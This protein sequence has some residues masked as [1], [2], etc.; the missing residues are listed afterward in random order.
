MSDRPP[1]TVAIVPHTHWD[2]EWYDTFQTFRL[3]LVKLLD[4]LLPMLESDPSYARFMLDGQTVVVDDYL[5]VRPHARA[6]LQ[7]LA[8]AGRLS[9]GPWMVLM[10]E[11][12]V[13]GETMVRDLQFGLARGSEL[14]GAMQIG[15][16]PDMFGHIAQMPQLIRLAGMKHAVAWRGVPAA[17]EQTAFWWQAPD[18]SR[19]RTEYLYGSYSNGRD[20]PQ[21]AKSLVLRAADY[22]QEL[23]PAR[24][25]AMLLMNGTDHQ[26]PQPWL[27][28]VVAEA[29][30]IQDDYEFVVTSLAEYLPTQPSDALVT[31]EG[32]LRSGARANLL[33]GVASNRV[34]VHRAC[35]AAERSLE[36]RAEP[37]SALFLPPDRYPHS[38]A[39]IAWRNLVCNSAHDSSCACSIDEVVDQV[40]VRYYEARQIGDGLTR[41]AVHALAATV[42]AALGAT[43]VVNPTARRRSGLVEVTLPGTGAVHIVDTS[44][45]PRPTQIIGEIS[46]EA[47]ATMVTG[48]KVRWVLDLMRGTEFAGRTISSYEVSDGAVHEIV[49]QEAG[50]GDSHRDLTELREQILDLGNRGETI[51]LRLFAAPLRRALFDTGEISGF[52]WSCFTAVDGDAPGGAVTAS[53]T[54]LANEHLLVEIDVP[55]GTYALTAEGVRVS[56]LGRLVDDGDGGDSYNY[57]P[58]AADR[59]VDAPDAVRV[60]DLERGSVRARVQI[61]TDYTWPAYAI[62]DLRSC[63]AR[64]DETVAVTVSTTLELRAGERF[65]RVTHEL[66][67][68]AR[69]HRLRAHFP[70]PA[71]VAGS[72][73]ECAFTV[74]HRGLTAEGGVQEHGLPTFPSRRFVDASDGT[75][76]LTLVHDGLLEYEVVDD[77]RELA[78]TLLRSVGYLSRS[79]PSMR[80]NPAGPTVEVLGAQMPGAQRA[81]YAV[82][83]HHGDWRA[84]DCYGAAD[85]LLVPFER[86]RAAGGGSTPPTGAALRVDGAEVSAVVRSPGGLVVRVFRT[87]PDAGP[88]AI[89]HEGA[90]AR[91]W[92]ID[93]QG[94][95]VAPF[96]GSVEL[97]PWEICTLQL[98]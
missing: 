80:P 9:V 86:A 77:G 5:E 8:A 93:L 49:L 31:I 24:L 14:G 25:D 52:G 46:G 95:P 89:E 10:D 64:S 12:M 7:R 35:A 75:A 6:A 87:D 19:V 3:R 47:Y 51:S 36:R 84:A 97:R 16:L 73:A 22:E 81:E 33:M 78:L 58:P 40:L 43:V 60:T 44:G 85:A 70:L 29:N 94:R 62:G 68:R 54:T 53:E 48:Q 79:E 57:S 21:D 96:E 88:V 11:F 37:L 61:D 83:I 18:G 42:D 32:E 63:S 45:T 27:G 59:V 67:N 41:D 20:L 72:D 90:P 1:I 65:L 2:R 76:G 4:T 23:G 71:R 55:T 38:L 30:A 66:D 74:V 34:D 13:S 91:G 15:Y 26:M 17:V 39:D 98:A 69:D 92:I 82:L 28:R 56:G 50:P